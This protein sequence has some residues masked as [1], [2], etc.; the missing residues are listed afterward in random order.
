MMKS[1]RQTNKTDIFILCLLF[2]N[3]SK[4]LKMSKSNLSIGSREGSKE[5]DKTEFTNFIRVKIRI[6]FCFFKDG[7]C[8]NEKL[9]IS[10]I[11]N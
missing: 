2:E 11:R 7:F 8:L 9:N 1:R 6:T 3:I 4:F 5:T 10:S